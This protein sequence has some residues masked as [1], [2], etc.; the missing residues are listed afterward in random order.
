MNL[1]AWQVQ[2]VADL[3]AHVGGRRERSRGN[4][5]LATHLGRRHISTVVQVP[6]LGSPNLQDQ[7][8]VLVVGGGKT[9][10]FGWR[11][12]GVDLRSEVQLDLDGLRQ[13]GDRAHISV[14]TLQYH[15]V[16]GGKIFADGGDIETAI[17]KPVEVR[18]L[19]VV[20]PD[21]AYQRQIRPKQ[22]HQLVDG[23]RTVKQVVE[24]FRTVSAH[25]VVSRPPYLVDEGLDCKRLKQP[26]Q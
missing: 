2:H 19:F 12:V 4:R 16:A 3:Q 22:P 8:V 11:D 13:R 23:G 10:G 1:S 14:N 6:D 7:H 20:L 24:V 9:L 25:V 15:R 18:V 21:H 5:L 26:G 17:G